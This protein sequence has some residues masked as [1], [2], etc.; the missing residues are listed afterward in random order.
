MQPQVTLRYQA[1]HGSSRWVS[2]LMPLE[3]AEKLL[4]SLTVQKI[5][6]KIV[7]AAKGAAV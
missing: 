5:P 4:L 2:R 1:G 6:A 3:Q 7:K